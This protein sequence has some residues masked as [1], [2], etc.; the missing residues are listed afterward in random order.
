MKKSSGRKPSSKQCAEPQCMPR[1]IFMSARLIAPICAM[2]LFGATPAWATE[3][4][5]ESASIDLDPNE[6]I[7]FLTA[8]V[9]NTDT[10]TS[11]EYVL[12]LESSSVG[13]DTEQS[14]GSSEDLPELEAGMCQQWTDLPI[15]VVA[16][17]LLP[18]TYEIELSVGEFDFGVYRTRDS[19]MLDETFTRAG[20]SPSGGGTG[21]GCAPM[22]LISVGLCCLGVSALLRRPRI[23]WP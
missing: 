9:C 17:R 18:G 2:W 5:I 15:D 4:S 12:F 10:S 19:V 7:W 13:S 23:D 21:A 14:T 11:N 22:S 20:E 16:D 6:D 3:L 8:N 1:S